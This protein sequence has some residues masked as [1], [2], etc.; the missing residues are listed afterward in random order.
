MNA[1]RKSQLR[2]HI[3]GVLRDNVLSRDG[4]IKPR[5]NKGIIV[6]GINEKTIRNHCELPP[7]FQ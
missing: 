7:F 3:A 2:G 1:V 6:P 5:P 4:L